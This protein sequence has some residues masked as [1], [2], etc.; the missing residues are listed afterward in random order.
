[1]YTSFIGI[2][3]GQSQE[4]RVEKAL[5]AMADVVEL[6]ETKGPF[7]LLAK[8]NAANMKGLETIAGTILQLAG[9]EKIFNM[10][11]VGEKRAEHRESARSVVF[12]GLGV[13]AGSEGDVE[14]AL[15]SAEG[16]LETY[17][18]M[19]PY[20]VMAKAGSESE[21]GLAKICD[22]ALRVEGVRNCDAFIA[23]RRIK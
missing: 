13:D 23:T 16:V 7:D 10:L 22:A 17:S 20:Q 2:Y 14:R 12:L 21:P 8:V 5:A 6:Y 11:A 1:M 3:V 19:Y 4:G 9:V 18:M 15:L